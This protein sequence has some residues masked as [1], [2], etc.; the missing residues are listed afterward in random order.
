M[1]EGFWPEKC[2]SC[3]V[4]M[5]DPVLSKFDKETPICGHCFAN[6][7]MFIKNESMSAFWIL[8]ARESST[9]KWFK[10]IKEYFNSKKRKDIEEAEYED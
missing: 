8:G 9:K 10:T 6:E 3:N 5:F 7:T 1:A 4:K 2:A